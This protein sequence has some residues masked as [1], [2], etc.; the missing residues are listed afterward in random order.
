MQ[1][2]LLIPLHIITEYTMHWGFQYLLNYCLEILEKHLKTF[3][4]GQRTQRW[5]LW[6]LF[7]QSKD[8]EMQEDLL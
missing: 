6:N 4:Q 2:V 8:P 1:Y 3:S 7:P 5:A